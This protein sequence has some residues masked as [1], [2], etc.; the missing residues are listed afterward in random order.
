M[1]LD[2]VDEYLRTLDGVRTRRTDGRRAWYVD[3]LLVA[4]ADAA[5]TLL[6]RLGGRDREQLVS[7]HPGTFGVPPRWEAHAKL[8]ADLAGDDDAVRRSLR[9]AW[10]RQRSARAGS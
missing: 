4:R 9:L 1:T 6:V 2:D 10:E 3:G 5:G 8:Q 7:A